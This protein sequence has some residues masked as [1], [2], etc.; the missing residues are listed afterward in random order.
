M[1]S[2]TNEKE[3]HVSEDQ[4]VQVEDN[5]SAEFPVYE[6]HP[7]WHGLGTVVQ[8]VGTAEEAM[9]AAGLDWEVGVEDAYYQVSG[10]DEDVG[11]YY[12]APRCRLTIRSD[13][14][15]SGGDRVLG[16]VGPSFVPVQN[17]DAFKIC[18]V[19]VGEAGLKYETVGSLRGG[20]VVWMVVRLPQEPKV[21]EDIFHPFLVLRNAH[22][23]SA[24]LEAMFTPINTVCHN[25]MGLARRS[26][27]QRIRIR[28][29]KNVKDQ[30]LVAKTI[31]DQATA[32]FKENLDVMRSLRDKKINDAFVVAYLK[33]LF[34]DPESGRIS[35]LAIAARTQVHHIYQRDQ[36]RDGGVTAYGLWNAITEYLDHGQST[37][38]TSKNPFEVRMNSLMWGTKAAKR[39]VAGQLMLNAAGLNGPA[40][41]DAAAVA[42]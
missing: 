32:Y 9:K 19:L 6:R 10:D 17:V 33:A 34:P 1:S 13:L 28:H 24:S 18:D 2:I 11:Q 35:K 22:D 20:R 39:V 4:E 8:N 42:N 38:S 41:V 27:S 25:S 15:M 37:R 14:A 31:L 30:L 36:D 5:Q 21:G 3:N 23:G 29:T 12:K 16:H 40:L 26:V 7:P